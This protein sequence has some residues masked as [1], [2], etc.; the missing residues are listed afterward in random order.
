M[1]KVRSAPPLCAADVILA[2]NCFPT[3]VR[4]IKNHALTHVAMAPEKADGSQLN[5]AAQELADIKSL[6]ASFEYQ[7]TCN[8][9]QS[10]N[11]EARTRRQINTA[12]STAAASLQGESDDTN[13]WRERLHENGVDMLRRRPTLL[14][15]L[16]WTDV[17]APSWLLSEEV[18]ALANEQIGSDSSMSRMLFGQLWMAVQCLLHKVFSHMRWCSPVWFGPE[19]LQRDLDKCI[20]NPGMYKSD[21]LRSFMTCRHWSLDR[22]SQGKSLTWRDVLSAAC[23]SQDPV[24]QRA[25]KQAASQLESLYGAH[26]YE[27]RLE[28]RTWTIEE[29]I[30]MD[31]R[32][33]LL[34]K[35]RAS[36]APYNPLEHISDVLHAPAMLAPLHE[37]SSQVSN[38]G[39]NSL[40]ARAEAAFM[41]ESDED[42]ASDSGTVSI[43][44]DSELEGF[45]DDQDNTTD[46]SD[47]GDSVD[48]ADGTLDQDPS[49]SNESSTTSHPSDETGSSTDIADQ[50][51]SL[52]TSSLA[53]A[54]SQPT[55]QTN[56]SKRNSSQSRRPKTAYPDFLPPSKRVRRGF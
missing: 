25:T 35:A 30:S 14:W 40:L 26:L 29:P 36:L 47:G 34:H 55:S 11:A 39:S 49:D 32:A 6:L 28:K 44:D 31:H 45:G 24:F 41:W 33:S 17:P 19:A 56:E 2:S 3:R 52:S 22:H 43:T 38:F 8:V 50:R 5:L 21:V 27:A 46:G 18:A 23:P 10:L 37:T 54:S 9:A 48:S 4:W 53:P 16:S 7:E 42:A 51:T 13:C 1:S 20:S 12:L 15:P